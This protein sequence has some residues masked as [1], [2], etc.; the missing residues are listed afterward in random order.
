MGEYD[1]YTKEE[2]A[3]ELAKLIDE[4]I[5]DDNSYRIL[6]QRFGRNS[7]AYATDPRVLDRESKEDDKR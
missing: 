1:N 7:V 2:K 6:P 3:E 4:Q 5:K